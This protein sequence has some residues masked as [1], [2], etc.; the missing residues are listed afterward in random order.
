MTESDQRIAQLKELSQACMLKYATSLHEMVK[1]IWWREDTPEVVILKT[2]FAIEFHPAWE[3]LNPTFVLTQLFAETHREGANAESL[4]EASK[5][6]RAQVLLAW[7]ELMTLFTMSPRE[8]GEGQLPVI[9]KS[10]VFIDLTQLFVES[11]VEF[12]QFIFAS[13]EGDLERDA[14][15]N[16]FTDLIKLN[17]WFGQFKRVWQ[18]AEVVHKDV[19]EVAELVRPEVKAVMMHRLR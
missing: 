17:A 15:D 5:Y 8:L 2:G 11:V 12:H 1:S 14:S 3:G 9:W 6:S 13:M 4:V 18:G 7:Q 16:F 19:R 10:D